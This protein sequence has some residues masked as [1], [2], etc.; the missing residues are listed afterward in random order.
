[1]KESHGEDPASSGSLHIQ[2]S[3]NPGE[4]H[5]ALWGNTA[6][7]TAAAVEMFVN[8]KLLDSF[9]ASIWESSKPST[10]AP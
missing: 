9:L 5:I 6:E 3:T 10:T 2:H 8:S 4:R 1:M 7:E